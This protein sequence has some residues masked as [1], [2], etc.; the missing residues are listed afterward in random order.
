MAARKQHS[1]RENST[2]VGIEYL[3]ARLV[4]ARRYY[5]PPPPFQ[6]DCARS[7][8]VLVFSFVGRLILSR[9]TR[10]AMRNPRWISDGYL[11][12]MLS[13]L[14]CLSYRRINKQD[15]ERSHDMLQRELRALL[16]MEG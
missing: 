2:L 9:L 3:I 5:K 14:S 6:T 8:K 11:L 10:T 13:Y 7:S 4:S 16:E 1:P 12:N 15:L